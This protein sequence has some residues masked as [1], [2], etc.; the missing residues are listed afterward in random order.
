M[1]QQ[2][3]IQVSRNS[4]IV[5]TIRPKL[6]NQIQMHKTKFFLFTGLISNHIYIYIYI[7]KAGDHSQGQPEG[8]LFNSYYTKV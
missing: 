4:S 1:K 3:T 6:A 8:P 7:Y 2:T 5:L